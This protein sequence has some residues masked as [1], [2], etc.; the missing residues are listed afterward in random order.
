VGG[1]PV[2]PVPEG[3]EL[4]AEIDM[5]L[6]ASSLEER[7]DPDRHPDNF[8]AWTEFFREWREQQLA[9]YDGAGDPPAR[10]NAAGRKQW[11]S[12]PGRMLH[13]VLEHIEGGNT[14]RLRYPPP[15]TDARRSA[16]GGASKARRSSSSVSR[17][18]GSALVKT[19]PPSPP[20][21]RRGAAHGVVIKN[22]R[23]SPSPP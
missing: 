4:A 5:E 20:R 6:A 13:A 12:A 8:A 10:K 19:E 22:E 17:S 7:N 3:H 21:V 1:V 2:P 16:N 9:S 15:Q 18:T 14:P 23:R 11:W